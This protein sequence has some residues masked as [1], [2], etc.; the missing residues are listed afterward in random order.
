MIRRGSHKKPQKLS[1]I[2]QLALKK[3]KIPLHFEDQALRRLWDQAV[4]P[5]ISAQTFPEHIK[6]GVLKVKVATSVW[7]H[8]LQFMKEEIT[9]KFNELSGRDA[10]TSIHFSIGLPP[11]PRKTKAPIPPLQLQ[12]APLK[13]RDQ[14]IIKESLA[15]VG[16]EELRTILERVMTKEIGRRRLME[17]KP[18]R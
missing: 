10:I 1:D 6:K 7:L 3:Q 4:G 9:A 13:P 16:D 18:R 14:R 11:A 8:Q 2:L 15:V 12:T 17:K 5:Q